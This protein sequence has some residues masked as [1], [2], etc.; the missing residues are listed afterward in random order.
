MV[1]LF[2][3]VKANSDGTTIIMRL[4]ITQ[5]LFIFGSAAIV[6]G[7]VVIATRDLKTEVG[8]LGGSI[9]GLRSTVEKIYHMPRFRAK[10]RTV[11]SL[12]VTTTRPLL[13]TA[14]PQETAGDG[15]L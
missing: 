7:G 9:D 13:S 4:P 1:D 3:G 15:N 6:L 10:H 14:R 11:P 8:N 12:R 5:V 2:K